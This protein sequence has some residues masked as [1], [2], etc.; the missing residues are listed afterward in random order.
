VSSVIPVNS[1]VTVDESVVLISM[2]LSVTGPVFPAKSTTRVW[3]V[4]VP[5]GRA[6]AVLS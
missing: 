2:I 6:F 5:S 1:D 4:Y 3:N